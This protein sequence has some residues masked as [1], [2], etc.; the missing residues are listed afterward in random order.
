VEPVNR[1]LAGLHRI[2][3]NFPPRVNDEGQIR[4]FK[5]AEK[6]ARLTNL[7]DKCRNSSGC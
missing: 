6:N 5:A 4:G 3:A 1:F 7:L 2:D